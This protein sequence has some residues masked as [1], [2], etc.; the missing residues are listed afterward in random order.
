[1]VIVSECAELLSSLDGARDDVD[2]G[3]QGHGGGVDP[4]V[5]MAVV[6]NI[7]VV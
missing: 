3:G 2:T 1:M 4:Q 6:G 5:V 7:G